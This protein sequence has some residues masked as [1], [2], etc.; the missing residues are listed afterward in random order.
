MAYSIGTNSGTA[1]S[2]RVHHVA[3]N[4]EVLYLD[5]DCE[6]F[7]VRCAYDWEAVGKLTQEELDHIAQAAYL[8]ASRLEIFLMNANARGR[9][10]PLPLWR[11]QDASARIGRRRWRERQERLRSRHLARS[12]IP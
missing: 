11:R 7:S 6:H 8:A 3:S 1:G 10:P 12:G 9:I 5:V 2:V 4:G